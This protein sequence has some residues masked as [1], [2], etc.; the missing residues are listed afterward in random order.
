LISFGVRNQFNGNPTNVVKGSRSFRACSPA[1]AT[2]VFAAG[3]RFRAQAAAGRPRNAPTA[4]SRPTLGVFEI[5]GA[6]TAPFPR[7]GECP[8]II[9][10]ERGRKSTATSDVPFLFNLCHSTSDLN[11]LSFDRGPSFGACRCPSNVVLAQR[12]AAAPSALSRRPGQGQPLAL[13]ARC[14]VLAGLLGALARAARALHRWASSAVDI[15]N[16]ARFT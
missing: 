4:Q 1:S 9:V 10:R 14:A 3:A 2:S 12:S 5:L 13:R 6:F 8:S 16:K 7:I 15:P 11:R